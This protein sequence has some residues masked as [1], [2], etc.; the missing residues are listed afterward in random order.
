MSRACLSVP[1]L[2][3]QSRDLVAG[4][5]VTELDMASPYEGVSASNVTLRQQSQPTSRRG[6]M[7]HSMTPTR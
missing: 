6:P 5:R 4:K 2:G 3:A 1:H 7:P